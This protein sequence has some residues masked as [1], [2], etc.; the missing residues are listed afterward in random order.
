[1]RMAEII[2]SI[3]ELRVDQIVVR[4]LCEHMLLALRPTDLSPSSSLPPIVW[5]KDPTP[6]PAVASCA[7]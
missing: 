1:M 6:L 7:S 3:A 4:E 5:S 2:Q